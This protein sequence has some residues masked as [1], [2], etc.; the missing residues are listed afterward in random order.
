MTH[1]D[2]LLDIVQSILV[3]PASGKVAATLS[4]SVLRGGIQDQPGA[5]TLMSAIKHVTPAPCVSVGAEYHNPKALEVSHCVPGEWLLRDALAVLL[6][7]D[8]NSPEVN[9]HVRLYWRQRDALA[10]LF[11]E[12]LEVVKETQIEEYG[13]NAA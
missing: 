4:E 9:A 7:A 6:N 2:M 3:F 12:A 8:A 13:A 1:S 11:H 5:D 10:G